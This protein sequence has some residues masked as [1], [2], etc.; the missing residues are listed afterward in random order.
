MSRLVI[1]FVFYIF[2]EVRG[3]SIGRC[4]L[5]DCELRNETEA[6]FAECD[7]CV[8]VDQRLCQRLW[9]GLN[10]FF[11]APLAQLTNF[12]MLVDAIRT[13]GLTPSVDEELMQSWYGTET[14]HAI[15]VSEGYL[16]FGGI[17]R[18]GLWQIPQQLAC[19]L[20]K[21]SKWQVT[22]ILEIGTW[23][24][25]TSAVLAAFLPRFS[26]GEG[27]LVRFDTVDMQYFVTPCIRQ[28]H[29]VFGIR[30]H[31]E[32]SDRLNAIKQLPTTFDMCVLDGPHTA[33]ATLQ[34]LELLEGRCRHYVLHDVVNR[35]I[36]DQ[37]YLALWNRLKLARPGAWEECVMQPPGV[38]GMMG[39]GI[40]HAPS[41]V[42]S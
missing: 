37:E 9:K 6:K 32:S 10:I 34:L 14:A 36:N 23:T 12:D 15:S 2:V 4:D 7:L 16:D 28:I 20:I 13:I 8:E 35:R 19:L 41:G 11:F 18:A 29:D 22:S 3:S 25:W 38:D 31:L 42:G 1:W 26:G 21:A 5:I 27:G 17:G 30:F 40:L 39:F 33:N 24:G